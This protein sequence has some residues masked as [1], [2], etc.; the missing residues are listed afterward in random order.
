MLVFVVLI[1]SYLY[2]IL[3]FEY[4]TLYFNKITIQVIVLIQK[5]T[6]M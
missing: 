1:A 3:K 6:C 5:H 2:G 4:S